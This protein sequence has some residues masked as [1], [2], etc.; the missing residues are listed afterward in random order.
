MNDNEVTNVILNELESSAGMNNVLHKSVRIGPK[1]ME[2]NSLNANSVTSSS[3][4]WKINSSDNQLLSRR[5]I[6]EFP[7]SVVIDSGTNANKLRNFFLS[8]RS[9]CLSRI[10]NSVLVNVNGSSITSQPAQFCEA[11]QF[12][13]KESEHYHNGGVLSSTPVVPDILYSDNLIEYVGL[14]SRTPDTYND[15]RNY[16]MRQYSYDQAYPSRASV[17]PFAKV[18][19]TTS[20]HTGSRSVGLTYFI[21]CAL[22]NPIFSSVASECLANVKDMEIQIQFDSARFKEKLIQACIPYSATN[23]ALFQLGNGNITVGIGRLNKYVADNTTEVYSINAPVVTDF[24]LF[25]Y[26]IQ[27]SMIDQIPETQILAAENIV[28]Y[29][30]QVGTI[31]TLSSVNV[32]HPEIS[33]N[34]VP[35]LLLLSCVPDD[36]SRSVFRSD[37]HAAVKEISAFINGRTY[38][39]NLMTP[40]DLYYMSCENGLKSTF[41]SFDVWNSVASGNGLPINTLGTLT[42][43]D[44]IAFATGTVDNTPTSAITDKLIGCGS[45]IAFRLSKM[46]GEFKENLIEPFRISFR[47]TATNTTDTN[48]SFVSQIHAVMAQ[49][50]V[51][52]RG[53]PIRSLEGVSQEEF[54]QALSNGSYVTVGMNKEDEME[55]FLGGGFT[56]SF[57]D[58]SKQF[59]RF[60]NNSNSVLQSAAQIYPDRIP[61]NYARE[62]QRATELANSVNTAFNGSGILGGSMSRMDKLRASGLLR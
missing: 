3:V 27:P 45:P 56:S 2:L 35:S 49:S 14:S 50:L 20:G 57:R 37:Y 18:G 51:I 12:F 52:Q 42:E 43:V 23:A 28:R 5:I 34:Q 19:S 31:G 41:Q 59:L 40:Q 21:R 26:T 7:V 22:K 54:A 48:L 17:S 55:A 8:P 29:A 9:D 30:H 46:G 53:A 13:T 62:A 33:L 15:L 38:T 39:Y 32:H 6:C 44:A 4:T 61:S 58:I 24:R 47:Y 11:V 16:H 1:S 10:M 25:Y 36:S 60:L